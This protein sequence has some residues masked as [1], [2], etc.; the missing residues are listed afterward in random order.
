MTHSLYSSVT[1]FSSYRIFKS[2]SVILVLVEAVFCII[3]GTNSH[4]NPTSHLR[5]VDNRLDGR[6]KRRG[7]QTSQ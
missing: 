7:V 4:E 3:S 2:I 5:G 1:V 6:T